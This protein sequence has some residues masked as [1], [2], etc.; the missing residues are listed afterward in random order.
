MSS[1]VSLTPV[2]ACDPAQLCLFLA[3]PAGP[4]HAAI[5]TLFQYFNLVL[6]SIGYTVAA[7]QSLRCGLVSYHQQQACWFGCRLMLLSVDV[8]P[9]TTWQQYLH[10]CTSQLRV[11]SVYCCGGYSIAT[12]GRW[13]CFLLCCPCLCTCRLLVGEV[14]GRTRFETC[15]NKVGAWPMS[16]ALDQSSDTAAVSTACCWSCLCMA[17]AGADTA[18]SSCHIV[19]S[20]AV[21]LGRCMAALLV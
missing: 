18:I 9:H 11:C 19:V 7:G 20:S 4:M 12:S 2:V 6:S 14:C 16:A 3:M 10:C 13:S 1:S 21:L 17:A 5:L 15:Y 8:L